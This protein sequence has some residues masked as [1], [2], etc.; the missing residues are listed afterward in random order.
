MPRAYAM[1]NLLARGWLEHFWPLGLS[2]ACLFFFLNTLIVIPTT[3]NTVIQLLITTM[4]TIY[5]S[6]TTTYI[7]YTT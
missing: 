6:N 3:Y 7:T 2:L 4:I 1:D 5:N